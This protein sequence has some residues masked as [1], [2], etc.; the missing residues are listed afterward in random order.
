M[1]YDNSVEN[2][3]GPILAPSAIRNTE[4]FD[5]IVGTSNRT[6]VCHFVRARLLSTFH[7]LSIRSNLDDTCILLNRCFEKIAFLTVNHQT[8]EGLWIKPF[9][10]ELTD[11]Y[12]AEK[13]YL[14]RVF[15]P[16]SRQLS[17]HKSSINS[18]ILKTQLQ[19]NL[20]D[21]ID[22]VP[23]HI[24]FSHFEA[25]LNNPIH[26]ELSVSLL[27]S[28]LNSRDLLQKTKLIHDLSRFYILL[29]QTYTKLI[30]QDRLSEVTLKSLHELG[31]KHYKNINQTQLFN[32]NKPHLSIINAGIEAVNAYHTFA[33]GLIRPGACDETQ[34][35]YMITLETPISYLVT[36][37]NHDEG[38]I[39]MRILRYVF[40]LNHA[41]IEAI[42]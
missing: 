19:M 20:Q 3:H 25:E 24:Q 35:F 34:R 38:N 1:L 32:E 10:E 8:E 39:V 33:D 31:E 27:R 5:Q 30:E 16:I 12:N 22:R 4:T 15:Y 14:N 29:H 26:S 37:K 17:E 21:F 40:V 6:K 41:S 28:T 23:I 9:Y 11:Q 13:E 36:T 7:F 18:L 2:L 42:L